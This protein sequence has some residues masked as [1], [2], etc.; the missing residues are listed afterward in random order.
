[1]AGDG[2]CGSHLRTDEMRAPTAALAAFE[3]AIAG[4]GATLAGRKNVGIHAQ[5]HGAAGLAPVEAGFDEDFVEAFGFG[6]RP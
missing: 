5:T 4:G 1:M 2:G 3:V 6:L